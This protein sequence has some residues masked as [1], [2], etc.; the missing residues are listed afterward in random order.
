MFPLIKRSELIRQI[1]TRSR[2]DAGKARKGKFK[3]TEAHKHNIS[4]SIKKF[5]DNNPNKVP[6]RLYHA[7]QKSWP[8]KFFEQMLNDNGITGWIYNYQIGRYSYD[9]AFPELKIDI[10]IDG[11]THK[12]EKTIIKDIERDAYSISNGWRVM[13]IDGRMLYNKEYKC[14]LLNR[15]INFLDDDRIFG[16]LTTPIVF[17][18]EKTTGKKLG[19]T[20]RE[21][22]DN[23]N[24]LRV[25]ML[26][27]AN[28]DFTNK[29]WIGEVA[30]MLNIAPQSVRRWIKRYAPMIVI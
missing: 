28:I 14:D 17:K 27:E 10:E 11:S 5:L 19:A 2:S 23:K 15:L 26:V 21:R 12:L 7:S 4:I 3:L 25:K 29:G 30:T 1:I 9:F 24:Q 8:E 16:I 13:R 22:N 6:Y 20:L 18:K